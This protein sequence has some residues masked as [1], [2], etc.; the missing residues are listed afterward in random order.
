MARLVAARGP[1]GRGVGGAA[2]AA[3]ALAAGRAVAAATTTCYKNPVIN[4]TISSSA[5]ADSDTWW[6]VSCSNYHCICCGFSFYFI[7]EGEIL[8]FPFQQAEKVISEKINNNL[9]GLNNLPAL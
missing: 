7:R 3:V 2:H 6:L 8:K 5:L 9:F 1:G 4:I